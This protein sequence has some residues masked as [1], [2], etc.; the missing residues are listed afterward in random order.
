MWTPPAIFDNVIDK[1]E[2]NFSI[3]FDLFDENNRYALSKHNLRWANR[4]R[5]I[6]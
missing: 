1:E 5:H 6:R 4:M 2:Y 3:N